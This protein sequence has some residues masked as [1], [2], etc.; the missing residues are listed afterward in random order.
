MGVN[1]KEVV[2][3]SCPKKT[4]PL[5]QWEGLAMQLVHQSASVFGCRRG[6][7]IALTLGSTPLFLVK[8]IMEQPELWPWTFGSEPCIVKKQ[9]DVVAADAK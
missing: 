1:F 5:Q 3:C 9:I 4:F 2:V 6:E 7:L 8:A